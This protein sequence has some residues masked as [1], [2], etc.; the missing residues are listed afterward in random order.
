MLNYTVTRGI[1]SLTLTYVP[2][3]YSSL[4]YTFSILLLVSQF[5]GLLSVPTRHIQVLAVSIR[6]PDGVVSALAGLCKEFY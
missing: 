6:P 4:T 1:T 5:V 3:I 2:T